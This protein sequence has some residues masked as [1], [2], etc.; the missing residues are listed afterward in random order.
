M[1]DPVSGTPMATDSVFRTY[2][3]TKPVVSVAALMLCERGLLNVNDR[4]SDHLPDF[5]R[6]EVATDEGKGRSPCLTPITVGHLL[7]HTAGFSYESMAPPPIGRLYYQAAVDDPRH[8]GAAVCRILATVP[9]VHRPGSA[10][11][12]GRSTDVLGHLLELRFGKSLGELLDELIF[13]PLEMADTGFLVPPHKRH[14]IAEP[15][16]CHPDNGLPILLDDPT[17]PLRGQLGGSGL[18]STAA[19]YCRF[20]QMLA[21]GGIWRRT[22]LLRQE[23]VQSMLIDRIQDKPVLVDL[24]PPGHGFGMGVAVC[25]RAVP[26][27]H[28]FTPGCYSWSGATGAAFFVDPGRGRVAILMAQAPYARIDL[29]DAFAWGAFG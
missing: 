23:T 8:D 10:W 16:V 3:L 15:F 28:P 22:R 18:N 21:Q 26:G 19:D 1:Q 20:L 13:E 27:V 29:A 24:L 7:S 17:D 2:S 6:M 11:Q 25:A 9:L 4:L 14:R 5:A 12:Y